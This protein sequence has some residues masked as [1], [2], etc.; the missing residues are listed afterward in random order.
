MLSYSGS[1]RLPPSPRGT[2]MAGSGSAVINLV[3]DQSA[4]VE[5][6]THDEHCHL[7]SGGKHGRA[8]GGC[9]ATVR[10]TKLTELLNVIKVWIGCRHIRKV[11]LTGEVKVIPLQQFQL[12][13]DD[14]CG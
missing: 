5:E 13:P 11:R 2:P 6:C 12:R 10:I 4:L 14:K 1:T 3:H 9:A 8:V 7:L